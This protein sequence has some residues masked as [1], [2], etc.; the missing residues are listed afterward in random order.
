VKLFLSPHNDDETL[1]GAF[2]ILRERPMVVVCLDSYVQVNRGSQNC[3]A[4]AR[5]LETIAAMKI[6][7]PDRPPVFL[8]FRDDSIYSLELE[9]ALKQFG[10]PEMVYAPAIETGGHEQH[11]LIGAL[12]RRVFKNGQHY[13]TY[14]KAGKSTGRPVPY[15]PEWP[16]LKLRALACY[17]SQIT[18]P[19]NAEHFLRDQFEY[20][21]C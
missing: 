16:L 7:N 14:T 4:D 17:Q 15:E 21:Q 9:D 12:A 1:F 10:Q 20:T 19:A 8:G 3:N 6:L 18:H 2:T 11:N 5:R 13:M